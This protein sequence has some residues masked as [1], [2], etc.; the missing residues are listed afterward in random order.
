MGQVGIRILSVN[1]WMMC[2]W[3]LSGM[4]EWWL[5][6][7]DLYFNIAYAAHCNVCYTINRRSLTLKE[8][9]FHFRIYQIVSGTPIQWRSPATVG[10]I[11]VQVD[12]STV[13]IPP[14]SNL[15]AG[16]IR[17]TFIVV[18][19]LCGECHFTV[20]RELIIAYQMETEICIHIAWFFSP[21]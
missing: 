4:V 8:T 9:Y 7:F 21:F 10:I 17:S 20:R 5:I 12:M 18:L 1:V 11:T 13:F 14:P 3:W 19:I 15:T 6:Y 2:L 16:T